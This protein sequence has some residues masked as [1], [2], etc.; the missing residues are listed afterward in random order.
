MLSLT[1]R[2]LTLKCLLKTGDKIKLCQLCFPNFLFDVSLH[3]YF[4]W[5]IILCP[6]AMKTSNT[7]QYSA[8]FMVSTVLQQKTS[9]DFL[10]RQ[11]SCRQGSR[12]IVKSCN[13]SSSRNWNDKEK[14][15]VQLRSF[16]FQEVKWNSAWERKSFYDLNVFAN[17][18]RLNEKRLWRQL[19]CSAHSFICFCLVIE[20]RRFIRDKK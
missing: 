19:C 6:P 2:Q 7:T 17:I 15:I 16:N 9:K 20:E 12:I 14:S 1:T 5:Y 18:W 13:S 3:W 8:R 10:T 11:T 4:L